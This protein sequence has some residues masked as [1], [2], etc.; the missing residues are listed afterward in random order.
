M[1]DS[2]EKLKAYEKLKD[3]LAHGEAADAS[4]YKSSLLT[5]WRQS[6]RAA[7][8]RM[9][10]AECQP[11]QKF[12]EV[13]YTP[14][15]YGDSTPNSFFI[16]VCLEGIRTAC[17]IIRAAVQEFED[18]E[19]D[20]LDESKTPIEPIK[21]TEST[22]KVFVVHGHDEHMKSDVA[23]FLEKL[24]LKVTI[25]HEQPNA[26]QTII[27][28]FEK[29]SDAAFAVILLSPDDVGGP[30]SN[31]DQM[32][33]RARQNVVFEMGFFVG[34]L[35]RKNVCVLRRE[36]VEEPSDISGVIYIPFEGNLWKSSL[37]A[38][39]KQAGLDVDANK[40]FD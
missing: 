12:N 37:I 3:L 17:G 18:Y 28:K 35:G 33:P 19:L 38:E 1:A 30:K 7:L 39:L 8:G 24:E 32:Q 26:G 5:E 36:T 20:R 34:R 29:H 22:K 13:R 21:T 11:L 31:V 4:W 15:V 10:G 16:K 14:L 9:L 25:L 6:V 27:E 40:T 23:R 2:K